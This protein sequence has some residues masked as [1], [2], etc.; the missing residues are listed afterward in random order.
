MRGSVYLFDV[1]SSARARRCGGGGGGD[2]RGRGVELQGQKGEVGAVDWAEGALTTC[3]DDGTVRIWREDIETYRHCQ[4][5]PE[6]MKW[7]WSWSVG[8]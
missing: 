3:A 7:G 5:D 1:T 4:E 2:G 6:E 8:N